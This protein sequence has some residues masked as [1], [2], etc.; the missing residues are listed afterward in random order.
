MK[1]L[2][3][4]SAVCIGLVLFFSIVGCSGLD[5]D[6]TG[7]SSTKTPVPGEVNPDAP[8]AAQTMRAS[9]GFNF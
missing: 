9:P 6:T 8:D 5:S 4:L 7:S 3:T 1:G 2:R